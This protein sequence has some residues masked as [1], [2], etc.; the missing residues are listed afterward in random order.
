M[1][2]SLTP[3][4]PPE[5]LYQT[6]RQ[7]VIRKEIQRQT[8]PRSASPSSWDGAPAPP[9]APPPGPPG[10]PRSTLWQDLPAV[11][12][13]GLLRHIS[14]QERKMQESLFEVLTSEASYQR[15]LRLL[16]EHF[17]GSRELGETLGPRE[18]QAL[19]SSVLRVK[20]ISARFLA[21]LEGRVAESLQIRDLSDV[22]AAHAR[23]DFPAYVDYVRNQPYQEKEYR[24]LMERNGPFGAALGRL[25]EHPLCQGLPLLSFL[26]LPFQRITRLKMLLENILHRA[27]EGSERERNALDA[28][29]CVS[30]IIE[31]CNSEV[32]RM[33]QMEELIEIAGRID[34]DRLKAVPI[35][36]QGRRL[37]K[38]GGL[39]EVLPRGSLFGSKPRTVPIHLLLFSDL[40][41]L[42]RRRSMGRFVVRDYGHRS[43]VSVQGVGQPP[44]APG[45][46]QAFYLT[47]LENHRGQACER[48]CRAPSQSDMHRWMEAFPQHGAPPSLP[49][50]IIYEDWGLAFDSW[51]LDFYTELFKKFGH[52]PTSVECFDLAQSNRAPPGRCGRGPGIT[53]RVHHADPGEQQPQRRHVLGQQQRWPCSAVRRL[54]R[55]DPG[56]AAHGAHAIAGTAGCSFGNLHIPDPR[57]GGAAFL[58]AP[59]GGGCPCL[60]A[61]LGPGGA[62][63]H[64]RPAQGAV[65][66][67][68]LDRLNFSTAFST[69]VVSV[70]RAAGL[71][72]VDRVECS[73]RY[74]LQ[75][76]RHP[77][78]PEEAAL[79]AVL[80]DRMTEQRY[81]EPIRSFAVAT[82]PAP[83]WH[84]DVLGG[85]RTELEQANQ[86]LGL[87]FD[88]WDLDF[89]T[90]LFKKFGRN[91]TSVECFDLA[92][93]NSEHSRHWFFKGRLLVDGKEVSESLFESIMRTQEKS[94]P[95]NVI[96][97]SDNSSAIQGRAVCSLWPRDP[98][99]PSRF[100][101]RTSTRHVIFTAETHNF[102]TGVAPY[103]GAATG[104]GGRIRDV[105]CTGRGAYVIAGTAGYSFG[106]LHIPGYPLPWEDPALPYPRNYAQPLQ[107]AL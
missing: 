14:P 48:L 64:P 29:A 51:D 30:Q 100:E 50:E 83:T 36:S 41:L 71:G 81:E 86:E 38:Q 96:K 76:A 105:Q 102:P 45:L 78:P 104:T 25:Q 32:G 42:T 85:G 46:G 80:S 73:R 2:G 5:P 31:E 44:P 10:A 79:V 93:S 8:L 88:S 70:C 74:L 43:L 17:V 4:P 62:G 101:K 67:R 7:A 35:V 66:Q 27:E 23:R 28:L 61:A 33:R 77:T 94:N 22:V 87:A 54:G 57:H 47:L 12:E 60:P 65:L 11:R 56:H 39:A 92:Q 58:P 99:R 26:L 18:R 84:V 13:S 9:P 52:N 6:Y 107:V 95:N 89:Y 97:F 40:L 106:N 68:Q 19:F 49:Q 20:E 103:S 91:P 82:H 24:A 37:E 98:S 34:F 55:A 53:V 59:R 1:G 21:A 3:F 16:A 90:E 15:S 63:G 69:N 72:C 75:C